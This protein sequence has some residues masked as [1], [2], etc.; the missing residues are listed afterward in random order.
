[1]L[2][3]RI[4]AVILLLGIAGCTKEPALPDTTVAAAT[5]K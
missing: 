3:R 5:P 4:L 2:S 1:M